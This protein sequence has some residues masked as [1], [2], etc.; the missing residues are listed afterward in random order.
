MATTGSSR[1]W[2]IRREWCGDHAAVEQPVAAM[3][4]PQTS[5]DQVRRVVE[6]LYAARQYQPD[7]MLDAIRRTGHNPYPARLGTVNF[8]PD[9]SARTYGVPWEG[10]ISC[11]HNPFLLARLATVRPVGDGSGRIAWEDDPRP[12]S[13]PPRKP[14]RD[15]R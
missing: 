12:S 5:A 13:P 8:D 1:A 7:E 6:L 14:S 4:R 11:G 9:G 10:E 15:V 2:V 3:L